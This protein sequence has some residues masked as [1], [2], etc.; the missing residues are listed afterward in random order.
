M[1]SDSQPSSANKFGLAPGSIVHIGHRLETE[2]KIKLLEFN[3]EKLFEQ[4]CTD[5]SGLMPS[6]YEQSVSWFRVT[7]LHDVDLIIQLGR[8]FNIHRLILEDIVNT[9]QRPKV[10]EFDQ[11]LYIVFRVIYFD[12]ETITFKNEQLSIVLSSNFILTFEET[13]SDLL[14]PIVHRI[15]NSQGKFR[16]QGADFVGYSI[17]DLVVDHYFLIEDSLNEIVETLE[18]DLLISP[19]PEMLHKIQKL[20]RGIIFLRRA[21]SPLREVFATLLRSESN[22]VSD[23]T[24]IYIRDVYDHTIRVIEG[25]DSYRDLI[26]GLLEIYLS[27][28]SNKMNE[29]M[30]ILTVFATIFI[31]LTFFAGVYGMNFEFMPELKWRW[32]YPLFWF[33]SIGIGTGL[34][35]YFR[36]KKW[37]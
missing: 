34:I 3:Q 22:L 9:H 7:G 28:I 18:D 2:T 21:V 19:Q 10:E 14:Q 32:S 30:K 12:A 13:E 16:S 20:K 6:K 4:E 17:M 24:R 5:L 23:P 26:T 25:L 29:I 35:A 31:P 11:I 37:L 8:E 27:S 15:K 1:N 36:K 33:V